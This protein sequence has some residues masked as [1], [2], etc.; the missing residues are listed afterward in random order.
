MVFV[1]QASGGN[2]AERVL[3]EVPEL[4]DH[5]TLRASDSGALDDL[6]RRGRIPAIVARLALNRGVGA[7]GDI[8]P[9]LTPSLHDLHPPE[10]L[11]DLE[12]AAERLQRAIRDGET[13]LVHGDY[14]V[15]GVSGTVLLVRLIRALGGRVE[16]QIP[17][18]TRD[19]YSFGDH[20]VRRA[21]E[22]GATLVI[23]VD[24]GT[25]AVEPIAALAER[26]VDVIV[27]DH[28]EPPPDGTLPP[29]Y[30]L[31]NPKLPTNA[32]PFRGLCGSAVAFKL[33]WATCQRVSGSDR[34]RP[35][36]RAFLLEALAYVAVA[37][38]CDV[39]PLVGE[40]R[41]LVHYG[42]KSLAEA[43]TPG[44][45]ALLAR[46]DLAGRAVV[47]EDLGF[48]IGPRINASGRMDSAA[49]AVEALLAE[50]APAARRAVEALE[51]LNDKR[52]TVERAVLAEAIE[53]ADARL[54]A[55]DEA[56]LVLS[57][58]GWH[59][60]VVGIVASRIVERYGRPAVVIG[61][62]REGVGRGSARSI[63]GFSILD[64]MGAGAEHM[65]RFGGHA[66][67]AGCE[68]DPARVPALREAIL[69][70][71]HGLSETPERRPLEI[72]AHLALEELDEGLMGQ[73]SRIE[74]CGERNPQP[75]LLSTDVRLDDMPRI[76]G[77]DRTHML[78]QI[79]AGRS[80][81]KALAFGMAKREP[82]LR[83]G[84]PLDIVYTPRISHFRGRAALELVLAD[85]RAR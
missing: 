10:G 4:P 42:L 19:G 51:S 41:V 20:S 18:R 7:D 36:L 33:A 48:K 37:T 74:P 21:T 53:Q 23:S 43:P 8:D 45:Q 16:W 2:G 75:V 71:A 35:D 34:V 82:E 81:F 62:D 5:W 22:V 73:I 11:P 83:L 84:S 60:G 59:P 39:V 44:L 9:W 47:A 65:N 49:R 55:R 76:I 32:Y 15:D 69:S 68:V 3:S 54:E 70:G 57:G 85:F 31:V 38:V 24:N 27:T 25:S 78:L 14:D 26:G 63:P 79:R 56:L 52:R 64:A 80:V 58:D 6:M 28:H 1:Q 13:I 50:D 67:A 40:N 66:M 46:T 12:R 30:A 72:D 61:V 77:Q 17:H 29:T